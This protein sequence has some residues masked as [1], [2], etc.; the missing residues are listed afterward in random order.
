MDAI[1]DNH[2]V[3]MAESCGNIVAIGYDVHENITTVNDNCPI[4]YGCGI[5]KYPDPSGSW[6][7]RFCDGTGK[8]EEINRSE[9]YCAGHEQRV[10]CLGTGTDYSTYDRYRPMVS[11]AAPVTAENTVTT[12]RPWVDAIGTETAE[13][14]SA[15]E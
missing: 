13:E 7:C 2:S 3:S 15:R 11:L 4:C 1:A 14:I 6:N 8:I 12:Q 10:A 9:A 5:T